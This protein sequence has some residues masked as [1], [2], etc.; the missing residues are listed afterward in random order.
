MHGVHLCV[1]LKL[2][3][4]H[5]KALQRVINIALKMIGRPPSLSEGPLHHLL[6]QKGTQHLEGLHTPGT[7]AV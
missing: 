7:P 1:G 6:S 5:K 4:A 2:I 3:M